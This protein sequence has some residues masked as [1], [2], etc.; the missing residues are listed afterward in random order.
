VPATAELGSTFARFRLTSQLNAGKTFTGPASDGEVEDWHVF[1]QP[2]NT[3]GGGFG[4]GGLEAYT[5]WQ[6]NQTGP[7]RDPDPYWHAPNPLDPFAEPIPPGFV[8]PGKGKSIQWFDPLADPSIEFN[9]PDEGPNQFGSSPSSGND[10]GRQF[11]SHYES[12]P[13]LFA[14]GAGYTVSQGYGPYGDQIGYAHG[15]IDAELAVQMARQWNVLGQNLA[16]NTEKTVTTFVLNGSHVLAAEKMANNGML[17]PGGL[18]TQSGFIGYWNEYN[19][20]PP[21]PFDP[22]SRPSWPIDTRGASYRDF[23]VAPKEQ[24]NVEWVEVKLTVTGNPANLDFLRLMLTSPEGTQ[25][26]LNHYYEDPSFIPDQAQVLSNPQFTGNPAGD[27]ST[28]PFVWTFSS[29]RNWGESTNGAVI[30]NPITGEPVAGPGGDPIIR[31]WELHVENWGASPMDITNMEIVWHG[32]EVAAPSQVLTFDP[33]F[34]G[35]NG[36]YETLP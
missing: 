22:A 29:N 14:N 1:I 35:A 18:S 16:P 31:N 7:F 19:A 32:K 11:G 25:S 15:V 4:S 17:V 30:L 28:S 34:P 21:A 33:A 8:S 3:G 36:V 20:D 9:F 23:A 26:E 27:I 5:T 10:L 2:P 24:I 13:G 12:M 6:T